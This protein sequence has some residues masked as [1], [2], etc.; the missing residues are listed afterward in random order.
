M[1][2]RSNVW[3]KAEIFLSIFFLSLP[4]YK[5]KTLEKTLY[6]DSSL[7]NIRK[8]GYIWLH[9]R[10]FQIVNGSERRS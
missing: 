10:S 9:I 6:V 8:R 1:F 7:R 2:G 3:L 4:E 5:K